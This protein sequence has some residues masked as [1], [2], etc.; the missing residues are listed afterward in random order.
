M[1]TMNNGG[2]FLGGSAFG[3][4]PGAATRGA[5][6]GVH[7]SS[8]SNRDMR[9]ML[10]AYLS[11]A[12]VESVETGCDAPGLTLAGLDHVELRHPRAIAWFDT[13]RLLK[14]LG[15]S[16]SRLRGPVHRASAAHAAA[17]A[18]R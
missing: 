14:P 1:P 2:L 9:M 7:T 11:R 12:H 10:R 5:A 18:L 8:C 13:Q 4:S 17:V 15:I 6:S 3:L 16:P